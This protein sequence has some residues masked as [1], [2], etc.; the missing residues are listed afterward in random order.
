MK[1]KRN[2]HS[3]EY[4]K[5]FSNKYGSPSAMFI[6]SRDDGEKRERKKKI[7]DNNHNYDGIHTTLP[8]LIPD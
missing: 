7:K 6:D 8:I 5:Y 2:N 3:T 1:Y 4:I